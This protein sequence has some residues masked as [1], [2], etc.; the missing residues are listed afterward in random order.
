MFNIN[1]KIIYSFLACSIWNASQKNPNDDD[2]SH[3]GASSSSGSNMALPVE[4]D[5]AE[6]IQI[7]LMVSSMEN[8]LKEQREDIKSRNQEIKRLISLNKDSKEIKSLMRQNL[9]KLWG[10]NDDLHHL[11]NRILSNIAF[12]V[13]VNMKLDI[14]REEIRKIISN[15]DYKIDNP[16][17]DQLEELVIIYRDVL[18]KISTHEDLFEE[19]I[20]KVKNIEKKFDK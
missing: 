9:T 13:Q 4:S 2:Y 3:P 1:K 14:R 10:I 18:G 6:F 7:Q 12:Y 8:I 19:Y 17:P 15:D 16:F 5:V 20:E 11:N